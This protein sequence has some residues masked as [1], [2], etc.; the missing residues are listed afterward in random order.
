MVGGWRGD[1]ACQEIMSQTQPQTTTKQTA[2]G[3]WELK[4][5]GH[6]QRKPNIPKSMKQGPLSVSCYLQRSTDLIM[7]KVAARRAGVLE[8]E[9][10]L[11]RKKPLLGEKP[12]CDFYFRLFCA[13][14]KSI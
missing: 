8:P 14:Y 5:F 13:T 4:A 12:A 11:E 7:F 2:A 3:R 6:W 10:R 1:A 9:R